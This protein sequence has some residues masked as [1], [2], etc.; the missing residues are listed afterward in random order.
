LVKKRDRKTQAVLPLRGKTLNV[1]ASGNIKRILGNRE[2]TAMVNS[3]G[4]GIKG[5]E[6]L[7][8]RR[9]D[10]IIVLADADFDGKNIASLILGALAYLTPK[11]LCSGR[12]YLTKSP[13]YMQNGNYL[14]DDKSLDRSKPF[15]HF[16]GLGELNP[17]DLYTV[18][19]NKTTRNLIQLTTDSSEVQ[20]IVNLVGTPE[21]KKELMLSRGL[22]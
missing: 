15:S 1:S 11:L 19:L 20:G 18:A 9:Y 3:I 7:N 6:D 13:L 5:N 17:D 21:A 10:R 22:I 16:K 12:V 2:I 8:C 14:E 4:V